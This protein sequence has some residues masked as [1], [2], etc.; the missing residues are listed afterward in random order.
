MSPS[1]D[2]QPLV[3]RLSAGKAALCRAASAHIDALSREVVCLRDSV[4]RMVEEDLCLPR[5]SIGSPG[6]PAVTYVLTSDA[7]GYFVTHA[8]PRPPVPATDDAVRAA[9]EGGYVE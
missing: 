9:P 2:T 1:F 7:A 6:N 4:E 3:M 8:T 5:G